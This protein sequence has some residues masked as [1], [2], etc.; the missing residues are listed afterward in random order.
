MS[1]ERGAV[2]GPQVPIVGLEAPLGA[3]AGLRESLQ[4]GLALPSLLVA[5][6]WEIGQFP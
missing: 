4:A 3:G 1:E 2:L 6:V 5:I